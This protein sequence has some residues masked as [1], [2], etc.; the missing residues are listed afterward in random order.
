M[1]PI[2]LPSP[3]RK[4]LTISLIDRCWD[5]MKKHIPLSQAAYQSGANLYQ[6]KPSRKSHHL[7]K[8][9]SPLNDIFLLLL[10]RSQASDT[11]D[12][13]EL[14]NILGS[15][16]AKCELHMMHVLINDAILNLKIR[17]KTGPGIHTN[18][19]TCQGDR[20]LVLLFI[21]YLFFAVK[22]LPPVI[23]TLGYH[24]PLCSAL[25]WIIDQDIHKITTDPKYADDISFLRSDKSEINQVERER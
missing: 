20:L 1:R 21:L 4:I 25:D 17:N 2:I 6:Q 9:F 11:V 13:K 5:R 15:I 22:P 12:R 7:W 10:D 3:L 19:R 16:L 18:I 23:S 24:K 8:H 14:M